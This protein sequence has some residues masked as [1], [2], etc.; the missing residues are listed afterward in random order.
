MR[1]RVRVFALV[2][3]AVGLGF[4]P[5]GAGAD[6]PTAVDPGL[7]VHSV[8]LSRASVAVSGLNVVPVQVHVSASHPAADV[9]LSVLFERTADGGSLRSLAA[10]NLP[11]VSGTGGAGVWSGTLRVP[12]TAGGEWKV[13]AVLAGLNLPESPVMT[14]PTPFDGPT[15]SV[16][17]LHQ[18]RITLTTYPNPVPLGSAYAVGGK[19]V[20][21]ATGLAYGTQIP[22]EIGVDNFCVEYTRPVVRST[23]AGTFAYRLPASAAEWVNCAIL[24]NGGTYITSVTISPA[25]PGWVG[26]L[27]TAVTGPVGTFVTVHG[28]SNA[29][30]CAV[31]L[32]RLRGDSQWR[33]VA[34]SRV[35]ESGR[36][37]LLAPLAE[38]GRLIFRA[39]L[40]TCTSFGAAAGRPFLVRAS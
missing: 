26:A 8:T 35:R 13:T 12:S 27:P 15:L 31:Q 40:P 3:I 29:A 36:I 5:R 38:A 2:V 9:P 37:T 11:R 30:F 32:Q 22:V 10:S 20:D 34:V 21:S 17:G 33:T 6:V 39:Y 24:T 16:T 23:T 7:T 18:P 1:I 4:S 19:V 25:R 28:K 14:D